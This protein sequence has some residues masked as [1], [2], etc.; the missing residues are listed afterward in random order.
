MFIR[1]QFGY[2]VTAI[3]CSTHFD[4]VVLS[5]VVHLTERQAYLAVIVMLAVA[6]CEHLQLVESLTTYNEKVF[7]KKM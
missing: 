2:F 3:S 5:Q 4:T 1:S 6:F 7:C